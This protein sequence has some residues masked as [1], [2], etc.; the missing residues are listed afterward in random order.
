MELSILVVGEGSQ[1]NKCMRGGGK[2]YGEKK[3]RARC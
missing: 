1:A 2:R 3:G